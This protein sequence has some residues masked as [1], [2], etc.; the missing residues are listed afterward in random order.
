META[1]PE[2]RQEGEIEMKATNKD[3]GLSS[4]RKERTREAERYEGKAHKQI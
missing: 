4:L 1:I 2:D 3:E